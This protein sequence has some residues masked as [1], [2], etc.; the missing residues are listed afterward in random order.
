MS[1]DFCQTDCN[2]QRSTIDNENST[3][4]NLRL[5]TLLNTLVHTNSHTTH[6]S[7]Q[8]TTLRNNSQPPYW[9]VA[10]PIY[11]PQLQQPSYDCCGE[12]ILVSLQAQHPKINN[13]SLQAC[14]YIALKLD[15]NPSADFV[16]LNLLMIDNTCYE[17]FNSYYY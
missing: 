14:L 12:A 6:N 10:S 8:F 16:I 2:V 11:I 1:D 5:R 15:L 9:L 13:F 4:V 7:P 3:T 17:N